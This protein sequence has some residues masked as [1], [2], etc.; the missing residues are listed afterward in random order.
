MRALNTQRSFRSRRRCDGRASAGNAQKFQEHQWARRGFTEGVSDFRLA[1]KFTN[2]ASFVA[3]GHALTDDYKLTLD[4]R[5][6]DLGFARFGFEQFRKYYDDRGPYYPFRPT[7]FSTFAPNSSELHR[8]LH[9]DLGKAFAEFGL[10]LPD[11]PR[12]SIGYE[13]Q[14]KNGEKST[15]QWGPVEQRGG[16][17]TLLRNIYP[18]WKDINEDVHI[19]KL[20]VSHDLAG[21]HFEDNARASSGI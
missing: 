11:W 12:I 19:V 18:A 16:G 7:G 5:K 9:L 8:D 14:F 6:E 17:T 1:Q 3:E 13:Y 20:D 2:G 21:I 15:E 4:I 10:T